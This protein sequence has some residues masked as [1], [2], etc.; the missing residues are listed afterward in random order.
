MINLGGQVSVAG[1]GPGGQ[2]WTVDVA[3][4][5]KRDRAAF[6]VRFNR[7][8]LSTSA[9]SERDLLVD[10]HRVGHLLDPR[11]GMPAPFQGSVSVWHEQAL[12]ADIL[13]TALYVMG[14]ETG[15]PWAESRGLS[16][17]YLVPEAGRVRLAA[18][19]S[20]VDRLEPVRAGS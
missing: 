5:L 3:D 8:S 11:T 1:P 19:S 9:G 10:G 4:P 13:S 14:P 7:G 18:T 12:V 20:F 6:S 17:A 16:A 15:L 2:P